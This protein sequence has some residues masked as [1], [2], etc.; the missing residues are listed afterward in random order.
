M[1]AIQILI[2][3]ICLVSVC[4]YLDCLPIN[5]DWLSSLALIVLISFCNRPMHPIN[6]IEAPSITWTPFDVQGRLK[7]VQSIIR[8]LQMLFLM[9]I[10]LYQ[11]NED[12]QSKLV[13]NQFRLIESIC[14]ISVCIYLDC[15]QINLHWLL[16]C[17]QSIT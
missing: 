5:L 10:R 2:D 4:I 9:L 7:C 17:I 1:Q 6:H 3:S 13:D 16:Q 14:L 12:N 15:L 11:I 8:M